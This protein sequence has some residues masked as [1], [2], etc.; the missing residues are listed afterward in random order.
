PPPDPYA[1]SATDPNAP[2]PAD[3]NAPPPAPGPSTKL[4]VA[5][6]ELVAALEQLAAGTRLNII[7]FSDG[8]EAVAPSLLSLD[9]DRRQSL[10]G[11]VRSTRPLSS[12]ALVPAMRT[13]MMLSARRIVLLSD[14][15]GNVGGH[16]GELLRDAREAMRG[17]LRI[18]TVGL[19]S[20]QN[21]E[22]LSTLAAESGGLYQSF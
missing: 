13:A 20:G 6:E 22:L 16:D 10:I 4:E 3:P 7:F 17:G 14:G 2:P 11:Y 15:H 21:A 18:D 1:T 5:Q 9:D 19:G 12:T 8:V